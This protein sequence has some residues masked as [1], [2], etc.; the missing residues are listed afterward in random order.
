MY[1][2]KY[3]KYKNKYFELKYLEN[4]I[5]MLGGALCSDTNKIQEFKNINDILSYMKQE[6]ECVSKVS[7]KQKYIIILYGPPGSGKTDAFHIA[8]KLITEHFNENKDNI[9]KTFI[10]TGLDDLV[11]KT[12]LKEYPDKS[13][14]NVLVENLKSLII[15]K[16]S[17]NKKYEELTNDDKKKIINDN[18][19]PFYKQDKKQEEKSSL[20]RGQFDIYNLARNEID[21]VSSLLLWFAVYLKKNI[22]FET[23][24]GSFDYINTLIE[25]VIWYN[26]IPIIIYPYSNNLDLIYSRILDRTLLQGRFITKSIVSAKMKNSINNFNI[27]INKYKNKTISRKNIIIASYNNSTRAATDDNIIYNNLYVV[28]EGNNTKTNITPLDELKS[29]S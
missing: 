5:N 27:E 12:I 16:M 1:S 9:E 13:V 14:K 17:N 22:I 21:P 20:L 3:I 29:E 10:N 15:S 11:N 6:E 2:K 4:V 7:T 28:V 19:D 18:M 24:A 8:T 26:Y 25:L 23:S